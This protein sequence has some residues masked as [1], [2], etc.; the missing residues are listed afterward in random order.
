MRNPSYALT[1][2]IIIALYALKPISPLKVE[3]NL[4]S[5]SMNQNQNTINFE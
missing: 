2:S 3:I 1:F 5:D 4:E